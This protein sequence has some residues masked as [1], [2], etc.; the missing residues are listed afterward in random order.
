MNLVGTATTFSSPSVR[1]PMTTP[2]TSSKR[3]TPRGKQPAIAA[4]IHILDT[5]DA[6]DFR[7]DLANVS[8]TGL[9]VN[10]I[11]PVP[12]GSRIV[13]SAVGQAALR[14]LLLAQVAHCT[15]LPTGRFLIGVS[16]LDMAEGDLNTT[17]IPDAWRKG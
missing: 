10:A 15:K 1:I 14:F 5:A 13:V 9:A 12:V 4:A 16:I 3:R 8:I 7:A 11:R 6:S 17:K 2:D